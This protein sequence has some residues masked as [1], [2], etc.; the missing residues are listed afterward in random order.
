MVHFYNTF[1][2]RFFWLKKG[3]YR[4][5]SLGL[6][7]Y[8]VEVCQMPLL[9]TTT[10]L[11]LTEQSFFG[12]SLKL[13]SNLLFK[14]NKT[15]FF[16]SFYRETVLH[17]KNHLVI[18]TEIVFLYLSQYQVYHEKVRGD[19]IS[20]KF[21]LFFKKICIIAAFHTQGPGN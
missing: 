1:L 15:M 5:E 2:K 4:N 10:L 18:M 13:Y 6:A 16:P 17:W 21:S 3:Y 19:N 8:R 11:Y 7:W 14:G 9:I 20:I 12:I